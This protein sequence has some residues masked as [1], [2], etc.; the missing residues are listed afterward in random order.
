MIPKNIFFIWLG[1]EKP[2]YVDFAVNSFRNVNSD[3][4]VEL[5]EWKIADIEDPKDN[6]LKESV[7]EAIKLNRK[8]RRFVQAVANIYRYTVLREYG[9]IYLDCDT[10]PIKPFDDSLLSFSEFDVTTS[11][12]CNQFI[13]RDVFFIGTCSLQELKK[14]KQK[15]KTFL[16]P[17]GDGKGEHYNNLK[18]KFFNCT[19]TYGEYFGDGDK[20]YINHYH[21]FTWNHK[22]CRTPLCKWDE[23]LKDKE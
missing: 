21:D 15:N 12:G 9:G 5:L 18:E 22:K 23:Y 2:K 7:E 11:W 16:W 4:N 13:V 10:F 3:F 17:H 14:Q 8:D 20:E 1:D 6:L 19:L